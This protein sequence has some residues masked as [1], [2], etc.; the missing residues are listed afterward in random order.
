MA[1]RVP[2]IYAA[3]TARALK[4]Q[5]QRGRV[6]ARVEPVHDED[7]L[8]RRQVMKGDRIY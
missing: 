2:A 7:L 1:G 3:A 4:S 6:D 8:Q 5:H